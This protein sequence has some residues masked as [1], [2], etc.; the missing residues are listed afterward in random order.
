[1]GG[2]KMKLYE[3]DEA[4]LACIDQETGE[5]I[6]PE[7][8]DALQIERET[9]LENV[10][11]WIKDLTAEAAALK[12][13]KQAFAERQKA[14][15]TKAESLKNWLSHALAGEKFKTTRVAVSFRKTKSVQVSDIWALDESFI[16]Y[17]EPTAD[18]AAIKKAIEA[19]QEVNGATLVESLSLSVK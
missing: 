16:K 15:E 6:D 11:L 1:M 8:L 5:I 10:A 3:I 9:K 4:I 12:A 19:G 7:Q 14:A 17:A 13:E 2:I 18:K